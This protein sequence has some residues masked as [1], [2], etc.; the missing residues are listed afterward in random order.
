MDPA[1]LELT[2]RLC[3]ELGLLEK[4]TTIA[5]APA[6]TD[7]LRTIHTE[8]YLAAVEAAGQHGTGSRAHGLGT[9]DNPVF[10]AMHTGAALIVYGTAA[11]AEQVASGSITRGVNFAGGMHHAQVARPEG[12][13][14][15]TTWRSLSE[16]CWTEGS[17]VWP[18]S[19][20][21]PTMGTE[22]SRSSMTTLA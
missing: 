11:L 5:P 15:T 17:A 10:E 22:P 4:V 9:E 3:A 18:A 20:W 21:M 19:T 8:A 16:F 2:E 12:S 14:S 6:S 1:R 13:A 7:Q